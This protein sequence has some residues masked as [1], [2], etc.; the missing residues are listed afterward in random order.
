MTYEMSSEWSLRIMW[1]N[2]S[3]LMPNVIKVFNVKTRLT[4]CQ[5]LA[6]TIKE[7]PILS[8]EKSEKYGDVK[9]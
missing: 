3:N 6:L 8:R 5:G 4:N 7:S 2:R 1:P 9:E